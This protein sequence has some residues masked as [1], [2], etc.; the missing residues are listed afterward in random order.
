[1]LLTTAKLNGVDQNAWLTRILER[2][3][4]DWP[5]RLIED[6]LPSNHQSA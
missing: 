5:N 3:D 6:L 4:A 2:L 1:M